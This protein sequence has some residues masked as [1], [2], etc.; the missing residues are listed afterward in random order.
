MVESSK[1]S[2][3]LQSS[4]EEEDTWKEVGTLFDISS[5]Y[6]CLGVLIMYLKVLY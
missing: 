1:A 6:L 3:K 4:Y 2:C 5:K